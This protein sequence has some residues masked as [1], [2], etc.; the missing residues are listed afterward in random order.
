MIGSTP[1]AKVPLDPEERSSWVWFWSVLAAL[2]FFCTI[3]IVSAV[4]GFPMNTVAQE[5]SDDGVTET[6]EVGEDGQVTTEDGGTVIVDS[7]DEPAASADEGAS[8][9]ETTNE[10]AK[11]DAGTETETTAENENQG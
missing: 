8:D 7:A 1:K 6:I 4:T 3:G 5:S 9:D 11:T 2:A 10:E